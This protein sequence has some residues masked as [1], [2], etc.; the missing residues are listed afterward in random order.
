MQLSVRLSTRP[1]PGVWPRVLVTIV[2]VVI[3]AAAGWAWY[4]PTGVIAVL[5]ASGALAHLAPRQAGARNAR[6]CP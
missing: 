5:S 2:I 1:D 3:V 4:G 6:G